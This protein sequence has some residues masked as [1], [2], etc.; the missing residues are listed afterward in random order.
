MAKGEEALGHKDR[1]MIYEYIY[2]HPSSAFSTIK[3]FFDMRHSTLMYHLKYLERAGKII[4]RNEGG[5]N[6]YFCKRQSEL[7][8]TPFQMSKFQ[9]LSKSQKNLLGLIHTKPGINKDELIVKTRMNRRTLSY[10]L[11]KL[12]ELKFLWEV[13]NGSGIGYEF[14]TS[15][16]LSNEMFNRLLKKLLTNEIDEETFYRIKKKLEELDVE[17]LLK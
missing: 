9:T 17:D 16:K 13:N 1:K 3:K 2:A 5:H 11:K 6:Y 7:D 4:V 8:L 10:N 15:A 14:I 12:I